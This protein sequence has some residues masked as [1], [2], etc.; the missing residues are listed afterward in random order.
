MYLAHD[1]SPGVA[2]SDA[3]RRS[4]TLG[5]GEVFRRS[6]FLKTNIESAF[7]CDRAIGVGTCASLLEDWPHR[8]RG[9]QLRGVGAFARAGMQ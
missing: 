4:I 9:A 7:D 1:A 5:A 8:P 3:L 2:F 6:S